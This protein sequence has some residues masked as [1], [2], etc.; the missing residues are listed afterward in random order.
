[1]ACC[2]WP[3]SG[4]CGALACCWGLACCGPGCG[5]AEVVLG[6]A[7]PTECKLYGQACTPRNPIGPCMVSDEGACRI[8]WAAG[9]RETPVRAA[10]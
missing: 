8:W 2:S 9:A 1:M 3:E 5:C 4:D 10:E 7:Y 6:R